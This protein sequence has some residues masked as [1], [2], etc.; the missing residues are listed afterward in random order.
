MSSLHLPEESRA[1]KDVSGRLTMKRDDDLNAGRQRCLL[2]GRLAYQT[3]PLMMHQCLLVDGKA[4][5]RNG[6]S[7]DIREEERLMLSY[8][9]T[10]R[11]FNLI[12]AMTYREDNEIFFFGNTNGADGQRL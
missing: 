4:L 3:I 6:E 11:K 12:S 8:P 2:V 10:C 5:M 9:I 1:Y 7:L